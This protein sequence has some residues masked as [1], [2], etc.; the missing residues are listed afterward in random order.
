MIAKHEKASIVFAGV[1]DATIKKIESL[2]DKERFSFEQITDDAPPS[3]AEEVGLVVIDDNLCVE[4]FNQ[5][6]SRCCNT[7]IPFVILF[8]HNDMDVVVKAM[9]DK[10]TSCFLKNADLD[11]KLAGFLNVYFSK[12]DVSETDFNTPYGRA[13]DNIL[14]T[15][16]RTC[17]LAIVMLD[18][19]NRITLWSAS[20]RYM[21]GWKEEEMIG[22]FFKFFKDPKQHQTL[23]DKFSSVIA[24]DW[25]VGEELNCITKEGKHLNISISAGPVLEGVTIVGAL[26][27][28]EDI[29]IR[30]KAQDE[31][32]K[33]NIE[34]EDRVER[35]TK[36]LK[37][38]LERIKETHEKLVE[39]EKM[40]AL[41]NLVVGVAHEINTPLGI[42]VTASS[43]LEQQTQQVQKLFKDE[44]LTRSQLEG[45][46]DTALEASKIIQTNLQRASEQIRSFKLIAVDQA[47]EE[48]RTFI[49]RDYINEILQSL[50][51]KLKRVEHEIKVECSQDI[52]LNSYPGALAQIFT[53][54]IV[55]SLLHGFE[56]KDKG[57][58]LIEASTDKETLILNYSDDGKGMS[59]A[60]LNKIFNPFFTTKRGE[61]GSGLGMNIVYNIVTRSFNG[62]IKC[63]STPGK[64]IKFTIKLPL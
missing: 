60:D 19:Q 34:L 31:V 38:S 33:L 25:F 64:G 10:A 48:K 56:K 17:P 62:D 61:G 54:L 12:R 2:V 20:A 4:F 1:A 39:S 3:L 35:R 59:K 14:L 15:V 21:F 9:Q 45:Y 5:M 58:I 30:K 44:N 57:T 49:L 13:A 63:K 26:T 16:F 37:E 11:D 7:G 36:E 28:I 50:K 29:T 42:G 6:I 41:G 40:A 51:P 52:V 46:M 55:N 27:V 47:S 18:M 53:N 24:G 32:K 22:R 23:V 43:W 8:S